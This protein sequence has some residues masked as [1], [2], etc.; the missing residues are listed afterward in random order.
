M[1]SLAYNPQMGDTLHPFERQAGLGF[2]R[3]GSGL[4]P[5]CGPCADGRLSR[6]DKPFLR[7]PGLRCRSRGGADAMGGSAGQPFLGQRLIGG[8]GALGREEVE[9]EADLAV[10]LAAC[11]GPRA[12]REGSAHPCA[13]EGS[14]FGRGRARCDRAARRSCWTSSGPAAPAATA[15]WQGGRGGRR[16]ARRPRAGSKP[17]CPPAPKAGCRH[18]ARLPAR[19]AGPQAGGAPRSRARS[20]RAGRCRRGCSWTRSKVHALQG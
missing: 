19:D 13:A 20:R 15:I 1:Q 10:R 8:E 14:N 6:M 17:P 7:P 9:R 11:H 16:G 3:A 2:A 4:I 12:T 5:P 18:R